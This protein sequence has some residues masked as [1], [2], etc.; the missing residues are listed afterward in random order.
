[1]C[2][3]TTLAIIGLGLNVGGKVAQG[4]AANRAGNQNA[5]LI[6]EQA[7]TEAQLV[8]VEDGRLRE[9]M[10]ATISKQR[11]QITGRGISLDSPQAV[12][13]G[14]KAAEE[15][16][17]ASQSLRSRGAAR[18]AELSAAARASRA[19]GRTALLTGVFGAAGSALT[20]ASKIWPSLGEAA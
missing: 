1:M 11:L 9:E 4:V 2:E 6:T 14:Q 7:A 5:A 15:L 3:P 20:G 8:A 10:R 12:H 13:M 18:Q 19:R 16:S 17:Y